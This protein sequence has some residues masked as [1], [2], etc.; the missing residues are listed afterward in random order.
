MNRQQL[1]KLKLN[2][3]KEE[4]VKFKL[5]LQDTRAKCIDALMT[6]FERN[7][8]QNLMD[9]EDHNKPNTSGIPLSNN[10]NVSQPASLNMPVVSEVLPA[11]PDPAFRMMFEFMQQQMNKQQ[12]TIN[13]LL[14]LNIGGSRDARQA[15]QGIRQAVTQLYLHLL[16]V[17]L[18]K[19]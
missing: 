3:L 19:L 10:S 4:L 15:F 17:N 9:L 13:Q 1:E 2:E 5:P 7:A 14:A 11:S 16:S 6:R 8:P 18:L 12:E